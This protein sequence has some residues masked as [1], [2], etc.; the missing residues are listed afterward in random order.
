MLFY[1]PTFNHLLFDAVVLFTDKSWCAAIR[2]KHNNT[3]C[4]YNLQYL[5]ISK[6]DVLEGDI[7]NELKRATQLDG[8]DIQ[9]SNKAA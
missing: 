7:V 9:R 2:P 3:L 6:R 8:S 4:V 1:R 5:A